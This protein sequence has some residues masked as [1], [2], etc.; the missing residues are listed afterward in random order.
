MVERIRTILQAR[1]LT[2]T[3]FADAIGIAR[4]IVSHILSG[5]NKPSL[6]VVQKIIAAF[7]ELSLPWLLSGT[8]AMQAL[9]IGPFPEAPA[10]SREALGE[11]ASIKAAEAAKRTRT[12]LSRPAANASQV[13]VGPLATMD[14]QPVVESAAPEQ[15]VAVVPASLPPAALT[16]SEA[17]KPLSATSTTSPTSAVAVASSPSDKAIRRIVIFYHDGTFTEYRPE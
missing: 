2:P 1:Q 5:R 7:P 14:T 3:Q 10:A 8:G 6:E 12:A 13:P 11:V 17:V 9:P 4:P 16:E 15:P